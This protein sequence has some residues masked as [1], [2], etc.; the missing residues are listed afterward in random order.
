MSSSKPKTPKSKV[1][2]DLKTVAV[3]ADFFQILMAA[4]GPEHFNNALYKKMSEFPTSSRTM[5]SYEHFFRL[6]K[7]KAFEMLAAKSGNNVSQG[8]GVLQS[9]SDQYIQDETPNDFTPVNS[10]NKRKAGE[11]ENEDSMNVEASP[12]EARVKRIPKSRKP[13][14]VANVKDEELEDEFT[15]PLAK[16]L[17]EEV[18][19]V[20]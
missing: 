2:D 17:K 11:V 9:K 1:P 8:I 7:K 16:K 14:T 15:E 5:S 12:I 20:A 3:E 6:Y 18:E 19:D 13:K 10:R 4:L